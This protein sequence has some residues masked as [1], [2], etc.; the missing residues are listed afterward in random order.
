MKKIIMNI[1]E[2]PARISPTCERRNKEFNWNGLNKTG[3]VLVIE[4]CLHVCTPLLIMQ[5]YLHN[6]C[7]IVYCLFMISG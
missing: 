5:T 3:D 1:N 6:T 2:P 7:I 4:S